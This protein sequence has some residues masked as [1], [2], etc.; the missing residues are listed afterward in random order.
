MTAPYAVLRALCREPLGT[1]LA[2]GLEQPISHASGGFVC[3]YQRGVDEATE[4]LLGNTAVAR[5]EADRRCCLER[6]AVGEY[7]QTP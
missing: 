1:V 4:R 2:D 7:R 6:K 3:P 5:V